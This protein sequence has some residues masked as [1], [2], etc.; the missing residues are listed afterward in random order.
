MIATPWHLAR[1]GS[2]WCVVKDGETQPV[3]GGCHPTQSDATAHMRALYA[4]EPGVSASAIIRPASAAHAECSCST[5][6]AALTPGADLSTKQRKTLAGT[7]TAMKDGSYPI[8]NATDLANAI[9]SIGRAGPK[10]SPRYIAVKAHITSR[11]RTLGLTSKLPAAWHVRSAALTEP[12]D[13][14]FPRPDYVPRSWYTEVPEWLTPGQ[15]LTIS[16]E[17]QVAGYFYQAGACLIGH[18]GWPDDCTSV[19]PSP[20]GYAAFHQQDEVC[21]DGEPIR[22]GGIVPRHASP[23]G[24]IEQAQSHYDNP[25]AQ[26]ILACAYDDEHGGL[27]LGAVVPGLTYGDV[28]ALR[29]CAFSGD[30]RQF[31]APWFDRNGVGQAAAAA[32]DFFDCIGP[33][34]VTRP[35]L[36][37]VQQFQRQGSVILGGVGGVDVEDESAA[38]DAL[39]PGGHAMQTITLA[40]GTVL[41]VP[42]GS[43]IESHEGGMAITLPE[44]SMQAAPIPPQFQHN[45]GQPPTA[46]G[47]PKAPAPEGGGAVTRQEFDALSAKVDEMATMLKSAMSSVQAAADERLAALDKVPAAVLA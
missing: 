41:N 21:D 11:A 17:G 13:V 33:V 36:P 26:R 8:R 35:G 24:T 46:A 31:D 42:D 23:Y 9:A 19:D 14:P 45:A 32:V 44:P 2:Q 20:T 27:V 22:V 16:D 39:R 3:P 30:W 40:D 6:Q 43:T 37:L 5:Q 28:A 4:A 34:L 1:Q 10:G 47:P 29:R 7:G 15:G 18:P 25:D 12:F 38:Y